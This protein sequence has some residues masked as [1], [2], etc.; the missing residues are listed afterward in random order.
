MTKKRTIYE[1]TPRRPIGVALDPNEGGS[2]AEVFVVCDDG[3]AWLY[4]TATGRAH[5]WVELP[6]IPGSKRDL[7]K[8]DLAKIL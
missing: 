1:P 4:M 2:E 7:D 6:P 8:Q 5:E 3:S